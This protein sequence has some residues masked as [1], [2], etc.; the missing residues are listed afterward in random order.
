ALSETEQ[1]ALEAGT[2][3]F[4]GE[5]FSGRPDWQVLLKQAAPVLTADEQAFMDGP[6]EELCSMIDEW[7]INH[8][9]AD[10]PPEMW[11]FIKKNRFFGMIIPKDFGGLGF[12]AYAH[13]RVLVKIASMSGTVAST[14]C[15]PNSLGPTELLLHYGT[16]AQKKHYL[17]RLATGEDIPCFGLTSPTAGSDATSI[18]DYGVVEKR[19]VDGKEVL[20]LNLT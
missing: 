3:G 18:S 10:L 9:L 7:Q 8:E 6:V 12:S 5:L 13:H 17:P 4:E 14:V 2:V 19:V 15:V 11:A 16:D 1:V 20:G